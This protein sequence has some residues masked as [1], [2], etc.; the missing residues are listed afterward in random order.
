MRTRTRHRALRAL[1]AIAV[2]LLAAVIPATAFAA[3]EPAQA[4]AAAST[5]G[6]G[7]SNWLWWFGSL[8]V[9]S[10]IGIAAGI[11][12]EKDKDSSNALIALPAAIIFA[13]A[14]SGFDAVGALTDNV[15]STTMAH[16]L[17]LLI[18][19]AALLTQPVQALA[20]TTGDRE[21]VAASVGVLGGITMALSVLGMVSAIA[22]NPTFWFTLTERVWLA[23][24]LGALVWW[25]AWSVVV[26]IIGHR[27]QS[28]TAERRAREQ[29]DADRPIR[30]ERRARRP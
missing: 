10:A 16:V 23:A 4:E 25:I 5:T 29:R 12:H 13:F 3:M 2:G 9:L 24:V 21:T 26:A 22:W 19:G 15:S 8:A 18:A 1:G 28:R 27:A 7:T 20:T 14:L 6:G 30:D 17:L 11:N